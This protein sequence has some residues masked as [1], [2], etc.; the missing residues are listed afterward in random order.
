MTVS[1][2]IKSLALIEDIMALLTIT[3]NINYIFV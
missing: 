1:F 2:D 3:N